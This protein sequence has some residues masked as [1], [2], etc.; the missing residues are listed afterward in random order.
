LES[1]RSE[2]LSWA[3]NDDGIAPEI[4]AAHDQFSDK[5]RQWFIPEMSLNCWQ[6]GQDAIGYY[7]CLIYDPILKLEESF[8]NAQMEQGYDHIFSSW[9][10]VSS[11]ENATSSA[12]KCPNLETQFPKSGNDTEQSYTHLSRTER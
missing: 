5:L 7:F 12:D 9:P 8:P 2:G 10:R 4:L 3:W 6:N 1:E 11:A